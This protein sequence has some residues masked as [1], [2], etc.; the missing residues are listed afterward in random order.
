MPNGLPWHFD[1]R[2]KARQGR[3]HF[4]T[5]KLVYVSK[6]L[7][8]KLYSALFVSEEDFGV[9]PWIEAHFV[10]RGK[11]NGHYAMILEF[12]FLK[13]RNTASDFKERAGIDGV[14]ADYPMFIRIPEEIEP[15]EVVGF[16]RLPAVV[17]LKRLHGGDCTAWHTSN[18]SSDLSLCARIIFSENREAGLAGRIALA[19]LR[20]CPSEM[21]EGAAQVTDEISGDE[22][23]SQNFETSDGLAFDGEELPFQILICRDSIKIFGLAQERGQASIE[24]VQ[25][26]LRPLHFKVALLGYHDWPLLSDI[27]ES[28]YAAVSG[29]SSK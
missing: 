11:R 13:N 8:R 15:P 4:E 2:E 9:R 17:W 10:L 16:V 18:R 5:D 28:G 3:I 29:Q 24:S 14:K 6:I 12:P 22:T 20:Q 1:L 7:D 19:D 23:D 25:V 27:Q 21:I 26:N